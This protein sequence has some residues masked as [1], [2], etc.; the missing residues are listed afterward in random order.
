MSD[1]VTSKLVVEES[2]APRALLRTGLGLTV[3]SW[4]VS[5]FIVGI[6]W[7]P[8]RNPFSFDPNQWIRWDSFNYASIALHG[9]TFARCSS[10]AFASHPNPLSQ[11]WCGT[12]GWLPGF[13][14]LVRALT[15][16]GISFQ[17]AGILIAWTAL[18]AAL[19]LVWFGWGREL[20][21]PRA[22][23]M[24]MLFGLFPGAVYNFAYF[25][26][27]MALALIAG[28][29]IAI[30]KGRYWAG[31]LLLT[32][33]GLCYPSAWFAAIGIAVALVATARSLGDAVVVRRALWGLAGL[34]SI[35]I[36]FV[37]DQLSF[38]YVGAY[39]VENTQRGVRAT[40]YPGVDFLRMLFTQNTVEQHAIGGFAGTMLAVQALL[41]IVI[42][43]IGTWLVWKAW[44]SGD[45][46]NRIIYPAAIGVGVVL[47]VL[48]LSAGAG[49]WNRSIVLAA[50]CVVCVRRLPY[51]AL[52]PL[53]AVA[54]ITAAV[55][56]HSFFV[57]SLI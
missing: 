20:T 31:A 27:S 29:A 25:P 10:P 52:L 21:A 18:A 13:P 53:I 6:M 30:G 1:A 23:A 42:A 5:R 40:G 32:A 7:G 12:A 3:A 15:F 19:F 47:G 9:R 38:G 4:L 54:S 49:S 45:H 37:D 2:A 44:R 11:V 36:L 48:F 50:P 35:A 43:A 39:F 34:S 55:L 8:V 57:G 41:A 51:A 16:L 26:T 46:D 28:A 33:A 22:F 14:W 56:G 17:S 24:M